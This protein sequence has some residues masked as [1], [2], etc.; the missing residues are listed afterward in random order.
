MNTH[1]VDTFS[2]QAP[3]FY[4][5]HGYRE[6]FALKEYPYTGKLHYYMKELL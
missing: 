2:F 6:I 5:K 4:K 1:I 3:T